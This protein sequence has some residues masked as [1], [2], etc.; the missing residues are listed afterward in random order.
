MAEQQNYPMCTAAASSIE[1][2]CNADEMVSAG[3]V[4]NHAYSLI[5]AKKI[6]TESGKPIR[7]CLLRNPW[8]K[9]EWTG[10][11]SDN[12][13]CGLSIRRHKC[14]TFLLK[15]TAASGS[16]LRIMWTFFTL[17]LFVS[18]RLGIKSHRWWMNNLKGSLVW[19]R[20]RF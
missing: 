15:I 19:L 3:L 17:R 12:S 16:S 1:D 11:W 10:A 7:L 4:D 5:G 8:G 2:D 20:L 6:T 18:L 9:K 13:A 14:L